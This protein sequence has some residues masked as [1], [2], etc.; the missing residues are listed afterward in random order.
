MV[1][2]KIQGIPFVMKKPFYL[3][4]IIALLSF[5]GF[6]AN[7]EI[8]EGVI[9]QTVKDTYVLWV[10][11]DYEQWQAKTKS[12]QSISGSQKNPLEFQQVS[13]NARTMG[14]IMKMAKSDIKAENF[15]DFEI[16]ICEE[17]A[18]AKFTLNGLKKSAF[19]EKKNGQ[20][21][22]VSV[23]DLNSNLCNP[24]Q[25]LSR[26]KKL[27]GFYYL[28]LK[29]LREEYSWSLK[30]LDLEIT[31]IEGGISI[32]SQYRAKTAS[33]EVV[34][35]VH[36]MELLVNTQNSEISHL[37]SIQWAVDQRFVHTGNSRICA[38]GTLISECTFQS[39]DGKR[40][41]QVLYPQED[42]NFYLKI[43]EFNA[44]DE[45][46]LMMD[47]LLKKEQPGAASL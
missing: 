3:A 39:D 24:D 15:A 10:E 12:G 11:R 27:T 41:R 44:F 47:A 7:N 37:G 25:I 6:A 2:I 1:I 40:F 8:S 29:S 34:N 26:M 23:A 13:E 36:H 16:R 5:P 22:M 20:W 35:P 46:V 19:L 38:D 32:H 9:I 33:G 18:V 14:N 21:K 45:P 30:N 42:G 28:D 17:Q 4:L 31:E 43:F